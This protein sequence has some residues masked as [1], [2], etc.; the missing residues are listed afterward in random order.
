MLVSSDSLD[1]ITLSTVGL[2]V[3]FL[4]VLKINASN[5]KC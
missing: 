4:F 3:V 2:L 5:T 1:Y